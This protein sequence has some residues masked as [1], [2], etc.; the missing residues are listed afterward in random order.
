MRGE[1]VLLKCGVVDILGHW[2]AVA[3]FYGGVA[4]VLSLESDW[5]VGDGCKEKP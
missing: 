5:D 2:G 1:L 3:G 4:L